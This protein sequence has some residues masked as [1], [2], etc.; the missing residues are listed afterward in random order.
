MKLMLKSDLQETNEFR[1]SKKHINT[2]LRKA[3]VNTPSNYER[4]VQGTELLKQW[5]EASHY[6]SKQQRIDQLKD[7]DLKDLIIEI[8]VT[9]AYSQ[10]PE[11]FTGVTARVAHHLN[12]SDKRDSI[13]TVA[14]IVGV[15]CYTGAFTIFKENPQ[16]SMML[17]SHLELPSS[18]VNAIQRSIYMPPMVCQPEEVTN[19]FES[20]HRTFNDC[21][22]L[23]KGN[24]HTGEL[25]LDVINQQNSVALKLDLDFLCDVEEEPTFDIDSEEKYQNWM[26]FKRESYGIY[27]L[28]AK[29]GNEFWL[30]NKV[31]K[32]GRL[33]SQGYHIN[34]QGTAFKKAMIEFAQEE[35]VKGV[36]Q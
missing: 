7:F 27:E 14:E 24:G 17:Q 8:F 3:I 29:Q 21:L 4:V 2:Y 23:G 6:Q 35:F 36:P 5:R 30:T 11:L 15:L 26:Q 18:I 16:S 31:D 10:R 13:M 20:G 1:F 32:R 28:I 9:V 22:V 25:C 12:L 33:Y 19:N 34:T